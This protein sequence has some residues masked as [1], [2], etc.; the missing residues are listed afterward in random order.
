MHEGNGPDFSQSG[1]PE[2]KQQ[3]QGSSSNQAAS[4]AGAQSNQAASV[5]GAQNKAAPPKAPSQL[6]Q[7][8]PAPPV[9]TTEQ[10]NLLDKTQQ[11]NYTAWKNE[12]SGKG[13]RWTKGSK[14]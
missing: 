4:V 1:A 10:W 13:Q 12:S 9:L 3:N 8:P 14:K 5:A 2:P 11:R 7:L 6:P